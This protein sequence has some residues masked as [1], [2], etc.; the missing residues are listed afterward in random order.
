MENFE[1]YISNEGYLIIP[2]YNIKYLINFNESDIPGMAEAVESTV[3]VAG[4]DGDI[5]LKT[6]YE[7]ITFNIVC[8]TD[9]N[10]EIEE[11][12]IEEENITRIL[13][14]IKNKTIKL[15]F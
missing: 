13:K 15:A 12:E 1:V 10:L 5:S 6:T 2:E 8:Y 11:K 9:D 7:P 14:S 3:R 4:R